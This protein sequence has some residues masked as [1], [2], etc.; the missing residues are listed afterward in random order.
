MNNGFEF[1]KIETQVGAVVICTMNGQV[2]YSLPEEEFKTMAG[3]ALAFT[4]ED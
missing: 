3:E 4:K 2:L 1:H